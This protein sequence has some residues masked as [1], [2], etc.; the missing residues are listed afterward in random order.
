[1]SLQEELLKEGEKYRK[2]VQSGFQDIVKTELEYLKILD[3]KLIEVDKENQELK[4]ELQ[5]LKEDK[6]ENERVFEKLCT[7]Y[8]ER[9]QK[10]KDEL[11]LYKEK[12]NA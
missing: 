9:I 6:D 11:N 4:T 12:N 1:M 7:H 5:R 3:T 8:R 10:L 2:L